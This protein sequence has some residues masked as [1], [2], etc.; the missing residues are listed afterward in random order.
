MMDI[1]K[2]G[3]GAKVLA[4]MELVARVSKEINAMRA[5]YA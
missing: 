1:L 5:A 2:Y 3:A 4:P